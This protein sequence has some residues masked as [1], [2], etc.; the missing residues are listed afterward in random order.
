MRYKVALTPGSTF[1]WQ[2]NGGTIANGQGTNDIGIDWGLIP[3]IYDLK[4]T[5]SNAS[6]CV[7]DEILVKILIQTKPVATISGPDTV[8]VGQDFTLQ[9]FGGQNYLWSNGNTGNAL[10]QKITQSTQY[11]VIGK[12]LVCDSDTAF[13]NVFAAPKPSANFNLN[14]NDDWI[15]G[16]EIVFTA[17]DQSITKWIWELNGNSLNQNQN[18]IKY[19]FNTTGNYT[20][21]LTAFNSFNCSDTFSI[22]RNVFDRLDIYVPTAFTPNNDFLN[23]VFEPVGVNYSTYTL[24]I[25]D[26]FGGLL[27]E[28]IDKGWD[29]NYKGNLMPSA[30]YS[31][32][33]NFTKLNGKRKLVDGNVMLV[34]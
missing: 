5:E 22:N 18:Q 10:F 20:M 21:F 28:G 32:K 3:G 11:Y 15:K 19:T 2:V 8:C 33:I 1:V 14:I 26:H 6:N 7:G 16:D 29:G 12:N 17:T 25:Y 30:N 9:A 34:N 27:Y 23:D 24:Y 31:Y 4:V 13:K